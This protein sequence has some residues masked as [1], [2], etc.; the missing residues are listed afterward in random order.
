MSDVLISYVTEDRD[1]ADWMTWVL[2]EQGH[3]VVTQALDV[4]LSRE[5]VTAI[6]ESFRVADHTLIVLSDHL[7]NTD[8]DQPSIASMLRQAPASGRRP[9]SIRVDECQPSEPLASL[10]VLDLLDQTEVEAEQKLVEALSDESEDVVPSMSSMAAAV[11]L[12]GVL[13]E[14]DEAVFAHRGRHL[15]EPQRVVAGGAWAN[16]TYD[17]MASEG[18]AASYLRQDVG[19]KLWDLLSEVFQE[20]V[21]KKNFRVVAT[22]WYRQRKD[23]PQLGIKLKRRRHVVKGFVEK[24]T[25]DLDLM[26]MQIPEGSF[27]MGSPEDELERIDWEGPQH[28]VTVSEFFMGKY[29][30]TQAQW[31][32]VAELP[33][34]ER[35]LNPDPSHFKGETNPVESVNW[36]DAVEFCRRLSQLTGRVYRLPT[37]AEW[38]YACRANTQTPFHFGET[39]TTDLAN[40]RGTDD[41]S[42][43]WSGS[44]GRGPKGVYREKTTPVNH[45]DLAN[46]FGL[47]DMHGNV[48]EWCE[49]HWHDN[50]EDAPADGSAW[51]TENEEARRV[52]RG[53]SWFDGSRDCRS[54]Y[55][56]SFSP[57]DRSYF[58]GF[59]VVCSAPRT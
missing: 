43:G 55:R 5:D 46:E 53:G 15:S 6:E 59:R 37:E 19:P 1:W 38:E 48:W 57:D 14:I 49:D 27:L 40:Y 11:S 3:N 36:Y 25:D 16:R 2:I 34:V 23:A 47:C 17:S 12:D 56:D 4:Q 24:L 26:M 58:F 10:Q 28:V 42:L 20:K 39:M 29:P 21:G 22:R 41:E 35:E 33:Q 8:F 7:L 32:F 52:Y 13:D 54:A 51:L 50:Y 45:F 44:Y 30:V 9:L 31:R 18:Y